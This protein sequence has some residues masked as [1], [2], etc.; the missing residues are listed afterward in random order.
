MHHEFRHL[1]V[2]DGHREVAVRELDDGVAA[3]AGPVD[4]LRALARADR[5][6]PHVEGEED[7]GQTPRARGRELHQGGGGRERGRSAH[8]LCAHC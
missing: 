4:A 7:G 5:C 2:R 6:A 3:A 1:V 8:M